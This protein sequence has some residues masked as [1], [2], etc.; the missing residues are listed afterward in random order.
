MNPPRLAIFDGSSI[1]S[2]AFFAAQRAGANPVIAALRSLI[3]TIDHTDPDEILFCWDGTYDKSDKSHRGPKPPGYDELIEPFKMAST[4]LFGI[5]HFRDD[6]NEADDAV[7]SAVVSF[8]PYSDVVVVSGDKDL[9]QLVN[10]RRDGVPVSYY[11]LNTKNFLS[12]ESILERWQVKHINQINI[13]LAILGD[14]GDGIVGVKGWGPK[15]VKD[16]FDRVDPSW[17]WENVFEFVCSLLPEKY[18]NDFVSSLEATTLY[19]DIPILVKPEP[20][21]WLEPSAV[22]QSEYAEIAE[23]YQRWYCRKTGTNETYNDEALSSWLDRQ[24]R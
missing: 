16:I 12:V 23:Q 15:R 11:C 17:S 18:L 8:G 19:S 22:S 9:H 6:Q 13:A 20:L 7:A 14:P 2:R 4:W 3:S 21:S 24:Q 5:P 10:C 1:Y